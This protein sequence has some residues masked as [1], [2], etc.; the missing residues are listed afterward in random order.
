[1]PAPPFFLFV[2]GEL[3][4][5]DSV[6]VPTV[7]DPSTDQA[8][9]NNLVLN[10]S[11]GAL[12]ENRRWG[13][14]PRAHAAGAP[15]L[16]VAVPGIYVHAKVTIIDD[17]FVTIGSANMN[18]RSHFHDAETNAFVV[19]QH[20]KRDP[21]NPARQLRCRLWAEHFG[22]TPEMG[23]SL[24]ADPLSAIPFFDRPW[25]AGN[26]WQPLPLVDPQNSQT[27]PLGDGLVMSSLG[28]FYAWSWVH[29]RN[30]IW[31]TM[32]DPTSQHDPNGTPDHSGPEY[33]P[34]SAR[35]S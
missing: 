28:A 20:L 29:Y 23:L 5:V 34:T 25:L 15:A 31:P 35:S 24:L 12:G 30:T 33:L 26:R 14:S 10:V 6:P 8:A 11:R 13:A 17:V 7:F 19:P 9:N 4:H 32:V 22:L 27:V 2:D 1:V 18:R 16:C 21:S 3:M